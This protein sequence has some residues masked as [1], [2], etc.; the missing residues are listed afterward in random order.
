MALASLA[1]PNMNGPYVYSTTPGGT[2]GKLP[3]QYADWPGGVDSFDVLTP[4]M[5]TLYSQVWWSPARAGAVPA[6]DRRQVQRQR[7]GDRRLGD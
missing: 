1:Q 4:P 5:T 6:R 2:P 3:A 7:D